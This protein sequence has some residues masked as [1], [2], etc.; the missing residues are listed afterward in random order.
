MK[1]KDVEDFYPLT[2][3]QEGM[4]FHSLYA[5]NSGMY[6]S[7][8]ACL[9]E[10]LD[11]VA[12]E[13][14]WQKVLD[15]NQTLRTAFIW[16]NTVRPIQAVIK[17][18][19]VLLHREDWSEA[20]HSGLNTRVEDYL[21]NDQVRGFKLNQAPLMRLALME[22]GHGNY[23][24]I[25]S[26]HHLIMDG[27]SQPLVLK[28]VLAFYDA[29]CN[30]R[31]LEL[32]TSRPFRDYVEWLQR[33]DLSRAQSFW[34]NTL[35][36]F[37]APTPISVARVIRDSRLNGDSKGEYR[38]R[39][40]GEASSS[41]QAFARQNQLTMN[42]LVQGAWA[43]L[44]SRYS[45]ESDVVFGA[46]VSGRPPDLAG[47]ET[48]TGNFINTLPVRV[49]IAPDVQ[50]IPWL[51]R[52]QEQQAETRQY[53]YSP[54]GELQRWSDAPHNQQLFNSI[55]AF[56]NYPVDRVMRQGPASRR[57]AIHHAGERTNYPLAVVV[58]PDEQ[59]AVRF[60]FDTHQFDSATIERMAGHLRVLLEAFATNPQQRVTLLPML[61]EAERSRLLPALESETHFPV[62]HCLHEL[63]ETQAE[64]SPNRIAVTFEQD[65]IT[66]Q[67]LNERA[68]QLAHYLKQLGEGAGT[69]VALYLDRSIEMVVAILGVLKAGAAYVP[70]D[71]AYPKQR[72][73]FVLED[74]GA[75][76]LLSQ[77]SLIEGIPDVPVRVINLDTDSEVIA[78]QRTDN[79]PSQ[80]DVDNVAYVIYTSGSTGNPKG[81]SITHENVVRLFESTRS[82]FR[83][84]ETD[85]WTLFHS[86]SFDFS[87]WELWGALLYG[88]RLVLVP[89][90][91]TRSPDRFHQL[92][93]DERVTVLN[94]TPSAFR[95]FIQADS[96]SRQGDLKLRWVIFGG[97]ALDFVSLQPWFERHPDDQ[98]R[99]INMY[100]I[101]ETTVH[102]TFNPIN[103]SDV[104]EVRGSLIG[105][106]IPD[107]QI[108]LLDD[109]LSPTAEGLAGQIF[110]GGAGLAPGYLNRPDLTAERFIPNPFSR[111][112]GARLY[113]TGDLAR[114]LPGGNFEYLGRVDHQ[115]K[116]RGFRIELGEIE[117]ALCQHAA[118]REAVVIA[119]GDSTAQRRLVAYVVPND[120]SAA[121]TGNLRT[122]LQDKLPEFIIPS[123][124]VIID[125]L[126]LTANGKLDRAALPAPSALRPELSESFVPPQDDEERL[127]AEIWAEVL[128]LDRVG[129]HDNFFALGGDS[130]RSIQVVA[131]AEQRGL[132]FSFEQ[133]FRHQTI[134]E[135]IANTKNQ[136]SNAAISRRAEPFSLLST[137][138]RKRLPPDVE[139]AYPL[140]AL[141]AGMIFHSEFAEDAATYHDVFSYHLDA[142]FNESALRQAAQDIVQR[143]PVLRTSFDLTSFSQPLQLVHHATNACLELFDLRELDQT[144]QESQVA[145]WVEQE[146]LRSFD[147]Q[148]A[149]LLRFQIHRRAE[150][151]FQFTVSFHHSIIDGW[152]LATMLTE[153]FQRYFYFLGKEIDLLPPPP[154][155][156]YGDFVALEIESLRS[157]D[158]QRYWN[159]KLSDPVICELPQTASRSEEESHSRRIR[160]RSVQVSEELSQRLTLLA[161]KAGVPLKSICL[162]AHLKVLSLLT[163]HD[164]ILTGLVC[165]GRL[166]ESDGERVLGLFLNTLP[167]R[168]RL[169]GGTWFQLAQEVLEAEQ[170]ML[171]FRRFPL[172]YL[173]Q[174][175][176]L[177]ETAFNYVHFH[178]YRG[179]DGIQEMRVLGSRGFEETNFKLMVSFIHG[180]SSSQVY[181]NLNYDGSV[182]GDEQIEAM[183]ECYSRALE[184]IAN[185]PAA[186]YEWATLL[187]ED[188]KQKLLFELNDTRVELPLDRCL[189]HWIEDQSEKTPDGFA[190]IFENRRLT[191][192]ELN[193][194]ANQL[195]RYLRSMGAGPDNLVAICME[196]S[197]DL[198]I[199][200]LGILKAGAGYLPLETTYPK[201]R[202]AF[203]IED[204]RASLL[205]THQRLVEILPRSNARVIAI[206]SEWDDIA[207]YDAVNPRINVEPDNIAY[208]IYTSGSTGRPKGVVISHRGICNRLLWHQ[209]TYRIGATDSVLQKT[210]Y[211]FDVSVWE[212]F[213]PL[214]TGARL[215]LARPEGHKDSKYLVDLIVEQSITAVHFVPPML[216]A[217]LE[218]EG[219]ERCKSLRHVLSS[220]EALTFDLQERFYSRLDAELHNLY[221]PT[222]A[223]VDVTF[224]HCEREV[225]QRCVPI[226]RPIANTRI[227]LL[228]QRR[229]LLRAGVAGELYIAG[230]GLA[231]G[232]LNRPDLTA[233]AFLP[234]PYAKEPGDRLYRTGDMARY[235]PD[236]SIEYLGRT[237]HQV[238]VHGFR[239]E[240]AEIQA[241]LLEHP[242]VRDAVVIARE[243]RLGSKRLVAY[244]VLFQS[245]TVAVAD[246]KGF[247]KER[248]PDYMVPS[249][250]VMLDQIP[251]TSNGKVDRRA[252][253]PVE[254][255]E[256]QS[257]GAY[258]APR[259][260]TEEL[261]TEIWAN[262]LRL[263]R[264][265][266][267]GDFFELG[268]NSLL[269]TQLVSRIRDAF[270]V[271]MPL[272]T[273]FESPT[274]AELA[275]VVEQE[276]G[277]GHSLQLEPIKPVPRGGQLP[278]SFGQERVWFLE[279]LQ[280]GTSA[281]TI[282]A[283]VRLSGPLDVAALQRAFT[284]IIR[285]HESLRTRFIN[286][287]GTPIQVIEAPGEFYLPVNDLTHLAEERQEAEVKRLAGEDTQR[288]FD[289]AA[290]KLLRVTLLRLGDEHHVAL[291]NMH[292][293]AS[294]AWSMGLLVNELATLY[295]SFSK[296]LSSPLEELA[297]QYAD[298][299]HWQRSWLQGNALQEQL[300]YWKQQ[301]AGDV[302]T[303][304]LPT[305]R[306]RPE[307]Q[308][309]AG[310]WQFLYLDESLTD[311]I[312]AL[313]RRRGS[314][315][316][317]TLLAAFQVLLYR[318]SGQDDISTGTPIAGRDRL[319]TEGLIGLFINTLV[320]RT[321]LSGNPTFSEVL[322]RVRN[323]SLDAFAHQELPFERLV[324]ELQPERSLSHNPLF[325][326]MFAFQNAPRQSVKIPSLTFSPL[327]TSRG[328]AQFDLALTL[329]QSG[330]IISGPLEYNTDLFDATT[331][332][333]ILG[334]YRRLLESIVADPEQHISDLAMLT[335][336]ERSQLVVEWNN[337]HTEFPSD[338]CFQQLFEA[339]VRVT[340]NKVA[341]E[342]NNETL[343]YD[344]LNRR[345]NRLAGLLIAEGVGPDVV[346]ALFAERGIDLL[347]AVLAVFKAGGA[348]LPLDPNYPEQR[349]AQVLE[350]SGAPLVLV[351]SEL[352][353]TLYQA[354]DAMP[355]QLCPTLRV[356]EEELAREAFEEDL[357]ARNVPRNLAYV[358]YTSGSTGKPKGA[359]VEQVGMVN[360]LYAKVNALALTEND[361]VAQN[362]SQCFDI[363]VWQMLVSLLVGGRVR[364]IPNE[365]AHDP[366]LLLDEIE[367]K[368]ITVIETV[369]SL[370]RAMLKEVEQRESAA[371]ALEQLR[372]MVATGEALPPDLC[373]QWLEAYPGI[374]VMN[375]YGP[376]ECSDD[377]THHPIDRAPAADT[378]RMPIGCPIDN[379]KI[380]ILNDRQHPAPVGVAGEVYVAGVGVGRGYLNDAERTADVFVPDSFA[381]EVGSRLYKTGDLGRFLPD[382]NIEYLGRMDHQVKVRGY[383]IELGEI[384]SVLS[385]HP[386]VQQAVV[387]AREDKP[388]D[389]RLVAYV[390]QDSQYQIIDDDT[391]LNTK[392]VAQWEV[393]YDEVYSQE[394]RSRQ[395][396]TLNLRV[397]TSSYTGQP[398]PEEEKFEAVEDSVSRVLALRPH[399]VLELGCGSG[400][401]LLRIAPSCKQYYG[402]DLSQQAIDYLQRQVDSRKQEL[403]DVRL[404]HRAADN[405]EGIPTIGFD[406]VIINEV[407]QYFPSM[408]YLVEV[409]DQAASVL[410]PG[411]RI[412]LGGIRNLQ[413]LEAFHTSVQLFQARP[414]LTVAQ[415]RHIVQKHIAQEKELLIHPEFFVAMK[416]HLPALNRVQIQLK[417][418]WSLN[419]VTKFH[420]DV[421]METGAALH[422]A[423][424]LPEI[425]WQSS[426]ATIASVRQFLEESRPEALCLTRVPN[427]RLTEDLKAVEFIT[428]DSAEGTVE[429]L[430]KVLRDTSYDG[431]TNPE[432]L[433]VLGKELSYEVEISW[434]NAHPDGSFDV[435]MRKAEL[436][437]ASKAAL[438]LPAGSIK[439][440]PWADYANNPLQ[441]VQAEKLVPRLRNY[442]REKLPDHMV[443]SAFLVMEALPLTTTGKLDRRALP[444]VEQIRSDLDD[445]FIAPRTPTE[446]MLASIWR[447][448]LGI[449]NIGVQEN[450]FD[451]GG[452]SLLATQVT[453]R[454]RSVFN[455]EVPLRT[456]FAS[457]TIA[458]LARN[459][460]DA[461]K[462]QLGLQAPPLKPVARDRDLPLSFAQQRLWFV[463]QLE[464]GGA[465]FNMPAAVRL[466]G[467]LDV[468]ALERSFNEIVRRHESLRTTFKSADGQPVQ[469]IAPP[470]RFNLAII[471]LSDLAVEEREAE[472]KRLV[473]EE[474]KTPFDLVRGPLMRTSLLKLGDGEHIVLFTTHHIIS[475]GWSTGIIASEMS[476]LYEA[477]HEGRPSPFEELAI[478]YADFAHWQREWL[479]GEVLDSHLAYWKE[480]LG[481][482]I[483]PLDL[484][485]DRGRS[486]SQDFRVNSQSMFL[487]RELSEAIWALSREQNCTLTMTLLAAFD[488]LLAR[489][490]GSEDVIVG[491]TL[492]NRTRLEIENLVGF[493]VNT[494]PLRA[495]LSGNPSFR[496]LMGRVRESSLEAYAHQDLP[497]EKLVEELQPDR[498][499]SRQ[500]LFDVLVNNVNT[501][502]NSDRAAGADRG[503]SSGLTQRALEQ[504]KLEWHYALTLNIAESP[505]EIGLALFYRLAL[506]S[507]ER[508]DLMM[509][510][511]R[512]LLEQIV[513]D[514]EG[515]IDSYSLVT[516]RTKEL[517]PDP[518]SPLAEPEYAPVTELFSSWATRAPERPAL[519]QNGSV[520]TYGDLAARSQA[521][522]RTLLAQ[523]VK[524]H[525]VVAVVGSRSFGLLTT[526][527]AVFQSGG[528]VLTI[529][530]NLPV[531]R[532]RLLIEQAQAKHLVYI[533]DRHSSKDLFTQLDPISITFVDKSGDLPHGDDLDTAGF[534]LPTLSPDD[535]A[536]IVFT[537]GTTGVP[538]G[539]VGC[540]KGL[541]HFVSWQRDEFDIGCEDRCL[542]LATLAVDV[543]FR[544]SFLSLTTGGCL[545]LL[546][547]DDDLG[548]DRILPLIEREKV[549]VLHTVPTVFQSWLAGDGPRADLHSLR[550]VFLVGEP[551]TATLVQR[552]RKQF[553]ETG[554]IVNLYG[555]TET[556]FAKCFYIV[557]HDEI[558]DIQPAGKPLP[559]TQALILARNNQLCGIGEPGQIVFRT[560]YLSLGYL[561]D[562]EETAK[563]FARNPFSDDPCARLNYTGDR[564]R[565]RLDGSLE[566]LGRLDDQV[567]I[568]GMRVEPEE[569]EIALSRHQD[570]QAAA[571]VAYRDESGDTA[572][573]ACVIPNPNRAPLIAGKQRY[574]L[575]N[576]MAV[577]HLN[578][579]ET[580]FV[581]REIFELQAYFRHG[582]TLDDGCC[583]F[584]VG[585][586]IGMFTMFVSQL[587]RNAKVYAF[588]PNPTVFELLRLNTSLYGPNAEVFN[589]GFSD[590]TEHAPFTF[591]PRSTLLSGFYADAEAE[592]KVT[593]T[594]MVNKLRLDTGEMSDV[595]EMADEILTERFASQTF[596]ASLR[597]LSS[598]I[599]E[600]SIERIDLLKI[601]A[602]KSEISILNGIRDEHWPRIEQVA[603]EVDV[604]ENLDLILS[605]L[606]RQGFE[607]ATYQD[608]L[609]VDTPLCYIYAVRPSSSRKLSKETAAHEH[610]LPVPILS[611]P[612]LSSEELRRFLNRDLPDYMV[613]SSFVMME[614]LPRT[615]S[616]KVDRAAL[617]AAGKN[618]S[619][620]NEQ[621]VAPRNQIE[622]VL[623]VFWAEV[624]RQDRISVT[625]NFFELGGHSLIA[626]RVIS[627]VR[628]AFQIELPLRLLFEAP[629]IEGMA[630]AIQARMNSGLV[631][632]T[633]PIERVSRDQQLPMSFAQQRLWFLYQWSPDNP[634]YN[635][636]ASVRLTGPFEIDVLDR[637]INEIISRHE[638]LR[639]TF[640]VVDAVPVQVITPT[641]RLKVPVI[642]LSDLSPGEREAEARR[643]ALLEASE[644]FDLS[645]GPLLR[646]ILLRLGPID[647]VA[648]LTMHHIISDGWSMG[649]LI[650]EIAAL[651][652]AFSTG[653]PSPL[654][655]LAIQYADF[656]DWQRKWL[657]GEVLEEQLEYWKRQIEGCP[658]VLNLFTDRP[659]PVAHSWRGASQSFSL[660]QQ[661]SESLEALARRQGVTL[662]ML[663]LAAFQTLLH[664]YTGESDFSVGTPIAGRNRLETEGL[665]GFFVNTLLM[666]AHLSGNPRFNDALSRIRNT[667]LAAYAHQDLPFEMLVDHLQPERDLSHTPLFQVMFVFQN[668]PRENMRLSDLKL[669][670][671][672]VESGTAKY[673]LTFALAESSTG[674]GGLVEFKTD[675]FESATIERMIE[676]FVILLEGIVV[677]P[678]SRISEYP[679]L[680]DPERRRLL[681]E[682]TGRKPD[683]SNQHCIHELFERR[684]ESDPERVAVVLGQ[685]TLTYGQL[686]ERANRLARLLR[687]KG[688]GPDQLVVIFMERSLEMI[689]AV[690]GVLKAGAAYVP[691][692]PA[693]PRQRVSFVLTDTGANMVLTQND[694]LDQL[695]DHDAQTICLDS[696]SPLIDEQSVLN[697]SNVASSD[698][699]AYVIYTSGS[700]GSPKGVMVT[701]ANVV[702]LLTST[703]PWFGFC[704]KDVW[705]LFH[706]Y[707]F[708][709]SVWEM[710]GAL[711]YGGRLVVVP[712]I[713]SRS[714]EA[715]YD[716][717]CQERVTVLN[718]TP[719][720]FRQFVAADSIDAR[721]L[722]LR[723][724]IFGG[725]ALDL[726]SLRPWFDKHPDDNPT[727]VNMYGITET[728]VHVTYRPISAEDLK[729]AP[730]SMIGGPIPDL[731]MYVL[732]PGLQV[733]PTG[734]PGEIYV[735]GAG[736]ARGYLNHPDLTADR[737]VPNPF[738]ND[739]GERLYKTGDLGRITSNRD[740][741]YLGRIDDQVKIRGFRIELGE[742]E[743]AINQHPSI[744]DAAVV[745]RA[746]DS[747]EKRLIAYIVAQDHDPV[748]T[749]E[750]R[751]FLTEKLPDYML[752]S[753]FVMMDKLPLTTNG[754][755]NRKA[756]PV[757]GTI[758]PGDHED[759]EEAVTPEE[760]VLAE[761]WASVLRLEKVGVNDN[762]F[763]LG[764]DSIRTIHVRS[765]A[766]ER[767]LDFTLQDLF[768][769]QTIRGLAQH[770]RSLNPN[771]AP[772]THRP[773][774]RLLSG[775]D[776]ERMPAGVEDAYP[777]ARLQAGM[778]FHSEYWNNTA[779]YHE[780]L[781]FHLRAPFETAALNAAVQNIVSRYPILRTSFDL[782]SF[783]EP[784]QLVHSAVEAPLHVDDLSE[785]SEGEQEQAID[786]W[787]TREKSSRFDWTRA[788]LL[789]F[790]IHLRGENTFQFSFSFHHA[791]LDGWSVATMFTELFQHYLSILG[792]QVYEL[793]PPPLASYGDFVAL[794]REAIDST[795]SRRYWLDKLADS[796]P[797]R[798][799]RWPVTKTQPHTRDRVQRKR[800]P[801]PA[802]VSEGLKRLSEA[803][804]VPLKSVLLAA[805]LRVLSLLCG[806]R[807]VVT[808]IVSNGRPEGAGGERVLGLF[809]NTLPLRVN[810]QRGN[811]V[812]LVKQA[813]AAE[814]E[815]MPHRR[816][817]LA[818][819]QNMKAGQPLYEAAFNYL[820]FHVYQGLADMGDVRVLGSKGFEETSIS[821]FATF[822]QSLNTSAV[823]LTLDYDSTEFS[824]DQ[825]EAVSGYYARTLEAL[826]TD[827]NARFDLA[828]P[829]SKREKR[830]LLVEWNATRRES[831]HH[832]PVH[833]MFERQVELTPDLIAVE[834]ETS[835]V[836]Y[837]Q[838]NARANQ[839]AAY[840]RSKGVVLDTR[841]GICVE[842]SI[843][844]VVGLLGILKAGGAYVP[845]D[846]EYPEQRLS[847]MLDHSRTP[848]VLT[849]DRLVESLPETR[850]SL[851][852]LDRDWMGI[853]RFDPSNHQDVTTGDNL[854]YVIYT[855]GSTGEPKG[856]MITHRSLANQMRWM[857]ETFP[858]APED[859]LL[860]KTSFSFD[861]SVWEFYAPL[862]SG[863]RLVMARPGGHKDA[864]YL[865]NTITARQIHTVQ[866]VPSLLRVLLEEGL[867]SCRTLKRV[868]CGGEELTIDLQ[869]RF[870][871]S[872]IEATL[873]NLYGPTETTVQ[874]TSFTSDRTAPLISSI[875]RPVYNT[876]TYILDSQLELVPVGVVG[877]LYIGGESLGRGYFNRPDLTADSFIPSP[878]GREP[879]ARLY[880]TRDLAR[881]RPDGNIEY[882]SRGDDQIKF[883][884]FRIELGEIETVVTACAGVKAA[885]ATIRNDAANEQ[886][887]VAYILAEDGAAP[888]AAQLRASVRDQL[889]EY[890]V[891]S[892]FV[893]LDQFPKSPSGKV[894]R[895]SLPPLERLKPE[896]AINLTTLR[897]Q[898]EEVLVALW[899]ET[900]KI[901]AVG[902]DADFFEMG[903]HSLLAMQLVSRIRRVFEIDLPLSAI[904]EFP[905][906]SRIGAQIDEAMRSGH[907][908]KAIPIEP[909]PREFDLPLS[910]A[911]QRLWFLDELEPNSPAYNMAAAVRLSGA[912]DV[913]A[914]RRAFSEITRR[915]EILRTT[916][917][918]SNGMP[919]QVISDPQPFDL[920]VEELGQT[921]EEESEIEIKRLASI[922]ARRAFDLRR[923][924]LM[925][926]KLLRL[927]EQD[928]VLLFVMHHIISDGWS[929]GVF[930][931][932]MAGLY[933]AFT[934]NETSPLAELPIQYADYASWQRRYLKD[935]VLE[936]ELDFWRTHLAGEIVPL[937]LP[938]DRAPQ[939]ERT[940][941]GGQLAFNL[942]PGVSDSLRTLSRRHGTTLFMTLLAAFK[943]LLH[944]YSG[945][946]DIVVGAAVAGR[947]LAETEG[948][949]GLFINML[950]LR[951]QLTGTLTFGE[952]LSHVR[953]TTL[954]AF[955]HQTLP[956]DKIVEA[957]RPER[958]SSQTPLF[959]VAFGLQNAAIQPVEVSGL[960]LTP[961][962]FDLDAARLDLTVWMWETAAGLAASYTFAL[963]LFEPST[964]ERMHE[965]FETLL[966]AIVANPDEEIALL[967]FRSSR[968]REEQVEQNRRRQQSEYQ[969]LISAGLKTKAAPD[970]RS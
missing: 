691:L 233:E 747:G 81:V 733:C 634:A 677:N 175:N 395:D 672:N 32:P 657:Q 438:S 278:L 522:A 858:L 161:E 238:K 129:A 5:P 166:E 862:L 568:R 154:K 562:T 312:K 698:N 158:A 210:P 406:L 787:I 771:D 17:Q 539:V 310:D 962:A 283:P 481:D 256:L 247:L 820:H 196:R 216:H 253:P 957:V 288:P 702:R 762:F 503:E 888:D 585:A 644:N 451:L 880:K 356:I 907:S 119:R 6:V 775:K 242:A 507:E 558:D 426:R 460:D 160:V 553:P 946:D 483:Q 258:A 668:A 879:G 844:M 773:P 465:I 927:G 845:L 606:E 182:F 791:I 85:V 230:K 163:G 428:S 75:R 774:F 402:S 458:E 554:Q 96:T 145:E 725:E 336:Q 444:P 121:T 280:P 476:A 760:K 277:S 86:Y 172:A 750:L 457:P 454:I 101:T 320:M 579:D 362:A 501:P 906:I 270:K 195:A 694:L 179:M 498:D 218:E 827:P 394:T 645:R 144:L 891:P 546:N 389:K 843:E 390:V 211:G 275:F 598:I 443:P 349:I 447:E 960:T 736:L 360:H 937:D 137:E 462:S 135:I 648:L 345:A 552:W 842:R 410:A 433:W 948:L 525:D 769:H 405:L 545:L 786:D 776:L 659:R 822:G 635:M 47:V 352:T 122:F 632:D 670:W 494:L 807:D 811:W 486:D 915:H 274:V 577:A 435:V 741:Q 561:N 20:P 893:I 168:M 711:A 721:D 28:E 757:P 380:F 667:V 834:S 127:L 456:L 51:R 232:Y 802:E 603:L 627:R 695:P 39:L 193:V 148:Q 421:I 805:H 14:A 188:E 305:D 743:S 798:L 171:P 709:F 678:E 376:T 102:V 373:R 83:F 323:V 177:L 680:T 425:D 120:P 685:Q 419:E 220:G 543:I 315:L 268:G 731:G 227:H 649:I 82:W 492:S 344:L 572:L 442:L 529:D 651:Y 633:Q 549:T 459:V 354:L 620:S 170:E 618:G 393:I 531:G 511:F 162:A 527:I 150:Q 48:M 768:L 302:R 470:E 296:G 530:K 783:D 333:R 894:D 800:V 896:M 720:A 564:G 926:A 693:Y 608:E 189:H 184:A 829:L 183:G 524:R 788:P 793:D 128:D 130:I 18:V 291:F 555:S 45:G 449:Q 416:Q 861:A 392:Q 837:A 847:F 609:L 961:V 908:I 364:I 918:L 31:D 471:D 53:E 715:F 660:S 397:W 236:G 72:I 165:N 259:N 240:L 626:T 849:Q 407:I 544:E 284:E 448:I 273:L 708:D 403:P 796:N 479:Q 687:A 901:D 263:D 69:L 520:L 485:T 770:L 429:E 740:I 67:E 614:S 599:E 508:I 734:L 282:P 377:V 966:E 824:E 367:T 557:P 224:W 237:D 191:Y 276:K 301:L 601:N 399:R 578:R 493:F 78:Q 187:S 502:D 913:D 784:L 874:V 87:V 260:Q 95:Q 877:E 505:D 669:S 624:L 156:T 850:A 586:N 938:T 66:Y 934:K 124:F 899:S 777:I 358:I 697:L 146:R 134:R 343:T 411:G 19:K 851:V 871:D 836:S 676:H 930:V 49:R 190:V 152:S 125:S 897:T 556:N 489:L 526:L 532:Q 945:Q 73:A 338:L 117:A 809:L 469:V 625:A 208:A 264:V 767:G 931:S 950:P 143:H 681:V 297:I 15:R 940:G 35:N 201:D 21:Q 322:K 765:M 898:T 533:G 116:V 883:R 103:S 427:A 99:L 828:S 430:R 136:N 692:D 173:P 929:M 748:G 559:Q 889:P 643:L 617:I 153:M 916:F 616:G 746:E 682:C 904:F 600:R 100:G 110:V 271:N 882:R 60:D 724:V 43:L 151:K 386:G 629:T 742:I 592:K 27:W 329:S 205:L 560:P 385:Q 50:V 506:F 185:T 954:A 255:G 54:L 374:P 794:E 391:E 38:I 197:V 445:S 244:A 106:P 943:T 536:Y 688:I 24:F 956:L 911:Q 8:H 951:T 74:T 400:L 870:F 200:L 696:D 497:F 838:L 496:E 583:V 673:D 2:P 265:G 243:D 739:P 365:T 181:L 396:S 707:S 661:L 958:K 59:L 813:F 488:L 214:M 366:S 467:P 781:S 780:V 704:Q 855:S 763:M 674:L 831:R 588:E 206:D 472:A 477:F 149:P 841:V 225:K 34:R 440:K 512:Y 223:A 751:R 737:F 655:E 646:L 792:R 180:V 90:W 639:T 339:Q 40:S 286:S 727:L 612:V 26:Y 928:H 139:D 84:D 623:A 932:E 334:H 590:Q 963:D 790:Q 221:G 567:K 510:Q 317:M 138:D 308:T 219:V 967:E 241:V 656:A 13:R 795:E 36:G 42:T 61:T 473:V 952:L 63:F 369:P 504:V 613:P 495:D 955:T 132:H 892:A 303:L 215:V 368:G 203:I 782:T 3:M 239:I 118:V 570:V 964:I 261:L 453:S 480:A 591:F 949:I 797:S 16:K 663:L 717:V 92:V 869:H 300:D 848:I 359:M 666:R 7:S 574:R 123:A 55:V 652:D 705:T 650:K 563:R 422:S 464:P 615:A 311:S 589:F 417:G 936:N 482:Q 571:V 745:A 176:Q 581:Y 269:A 372:W 23:E 868:F 865:L 226:G 490:S 228:D 290:G 340:P 432:Q 272:R 337:T 29:F 199:G 642:D 582:I 44:L 46:V 157:E 595:L 404:F 839:L 873:H 732:Q 57:A 922:E 335:D 852:C 735:S 935:E 398:F 662:F 114:C 914:L 295:E 859:R 331:I 466:S 306:L 789:Q 866:F 107:L 832:E 610:L 541:S 198:V 455:V 689:V 519:W 248:L 819:L 658:P 573:R 64:V 4:L 912:L 622:E 664:R 860:Q 641:L 332:A 537:S 293:I 712:Y 853:D 361:V 68:N 884:G 423:R 637:S 584:D 719:S 756:L 363:S 65:R 902:I 155:T 885:V 98:M 217:F 587:W 88:G 528:V 857:C 671:F 37:T 491:M 378:V 542:Q 815:M 576:N 728:T 97:E 94:Q 375:A 753:A 341:V 611:E 41:L 9:L 547:E 875:G 716:L 285:R 413:L 299:A 318:L 178:V 436:D 569:V 596:T 944:K 683:R 192:R 56:E 294:D 33:Q 80:A 314:T 11:V 324:E 684:A 538:K 418:G 212:F 140:A 79:L 113:K 250:F 89:Y 867:G 319:E 953:S 619:R 164:D 387:L 204:A 959:Q 923:G 969:K 316:F 279:Q 370:L 778:L 246:L 379:T 812:D 174:G 388:G 30:G 653:A 909:V 231:R 1:K 450:F 823:Q 382:G 872:G 371:P 235:L 414:A 752:P 213:W 347:T 825:M 710:W 779:T 499:L 112:P 251:L 207:Q 947:T 919:V 846:P 675:L 816:F 604:S 551:L 941:R 933:Q 886:H 257:S 631:L 109:Y 761:I 764:G 141:Q 903:G 808:G 194:K 25:W 754:K 806:E 234:D 108:Y 749:V 355:Q 636:T 804:S 142:P 105:G 62:C 431:A 699:I 523:G 876:Q 342:F 723:F 706:S 408:D 729:D 131:K 700:T 353:E 287:E 487:P 328:S 917:H 759:F 415:L 910:F 434:V 565:Y 289:L 281:Y 514:P 245:E 665:I 313:S 10:G 785:M 630:R 304:N 905:T 439:A 412:F 292:H 516:L 267:H 640:A 509:N 686:N 437:E 878:F 881:Y 309:F 474:A 690:L 229:Q 939:G 518:A 58:A 738:G 744:K 330:S 679:L 826:S 654:P 550:S 840:L 755:L 714:P 515:L 401:L 924:P 758:R 833:R 327:E 921:M 159:Q 452:H 52:I 817:P 521:L 835:S 76:L 133:L 647:H 357:P 799:P 77:Q 621:F 540:H 821:F 446:E 575:Q 348:Y 484:P 93:I 307:V 818:E 895:R 350:Q 920:P 321:D 441:N 942:S 468:P 254:P 925:R 262:V 856:V 968:E 814:S 900:M 593:R 513:A 534:T 147:W 548:A 597:T 887:L 965:H 810:L 535:P 638:V 326:V 70:L 71:A 517:L 890:M 346:V 266:V 580:D 803:A 605:L 602:E 703:E 726:Q 701:H 169:S 115:V 252:L 325:Q 607:C 222:E 104:S 424:S 209:Q 12:F 863:A 718:Q 91:I 722:S 766:Q 730:G 713:I 383:R 126:P 461:H 384:E 772:V 854:A 463:E 801:I 351:T 864:S 186:R 478:Q 249:A 830:R 409:L 500:P 381:T 475:D 970:H 420:Y 566:V 298:F 202:L 594:Y 628:D 111:K 167:F 22:I